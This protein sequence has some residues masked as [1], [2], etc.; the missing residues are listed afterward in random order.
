VREQG[1]LGIQLSRHSHG[2]LETEMRRM[3]LAA[4]GIQ[5][6]HVQPQQSFHAFVGNL[7]G[8]G[9]IGDIANSEA[10]HIEARPVFESNGKNLR[11]QHFKRL[12]TNCPEHEL[13]NGAFMSGR[14]I[15]KGVV[16][17][18]ANPLLDQRLAVQRHGMAQIELKQPQVVQSEEMVGVLVREEHAVDD[19]NLLAKQLGSQVGWRVDE[20]IPPRQ[21]ENDG[22]TRPLIVGVRAGA[23]LTVATDGGNPHRGSRAQKDELTAN[24]GCLWPPG[25]CLGPVVV[26]PVVAER[27]ERAGPRSIFL[28]SLNSYDSSA[29]S[30]QRVSLDYSPGAKLRPRT[31][32][33]ELTAVDHLH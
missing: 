17:R 16:K 31:A 9:A 20:Q 6:E 7:V 15:W 32:L 10:Q 11:P 25:Q 18:P 23:H 22:T 27:G 33:P 8:V 3:R 4:Q 12:D 28:V 2:F 30:Q 1:A 24:V 14:S 29:S 5:D 26:G 21:T 13:R 19:A